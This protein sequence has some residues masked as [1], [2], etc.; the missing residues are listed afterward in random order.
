MISAFAWVGL[1]SLL[2]LGLLAAA[3]G[4]DSGKSSSATTAAGG[5][6]TTA[7]STATT[8]GSATTSAS[9]TTAAAADPLGAPNPATGTPIKLGFVTSGKST[10]I[11]TSVDIPMAQAV[12][13][14][15]NDY[16][17]G[18]GGHPVTLDVCQ[19]QANGATATACGNQF[20]QDN[21]VAVTAGSTGE[22]LNVAPPVFAAGI[23]WVGQNNNSAPTLTDPKAFS[24]TGA[25]A[26]IAGGATQ[27][28]LDNK[29]GH[30]AVFNINTAGSTSAVNNFAVPAFKKAG[31]AYDVVLINPGVPDVT[32]QM[33]AELAKKPD[34]IFV[35]GNDTFC[36]SVLTAA[37]NLNY[38]GKKMVISQCVSAASAAAIPGGYEGVLQQ[39]SIDQSPDEFDTKQMEAIVAKY[40]PGASTGG[41]ALI[42]YAASL[43]FYRLVKD[44]KGDVTPASILAT[45]LASKDVPLAMGGGNKA[46]CGSKPLPTLPALCSTG[47][48]ISPMTK[49][50]KPTTYAFVDPTA[51]FKG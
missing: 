44:L 32:P 13:K 17:G 1:A 24:L 42:A 39:T 43:G 28:M 8:A 46:N 3:C 23:P 51:L 31:L 41:T 29:L 45:I 50:G 30:I 38:A 36:Q 34:M 25:I 4:D 35:I 5:T 14:Y 19:T 40:A 18:I 33:S 7:A 21:V 22:E 9:A 2:A 15:A 26:S 11:D 37:K 48:L 12:T 6:A 20:V 27:Y 49:E 10:G 16:L 47:T